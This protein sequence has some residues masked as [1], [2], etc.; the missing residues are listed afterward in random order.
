MIVDSAVTKS[1]NKLTFIHYAGTNGYVLYHH[2]N[3]KTY[4]E[5]YSIP[6]IHN[7]NNKDTVAIP[8]FILSSIIVL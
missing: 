4:P 5:V 3:T 6:S 7:N 8:T 2:Y 1:K